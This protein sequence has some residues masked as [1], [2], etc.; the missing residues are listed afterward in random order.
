MTISFA[1]ALSGT[2]GQAIIVALAVLA[3]LAAVIVLLQS[4]GTR[5]QKVEQHLTGYIDTA[6][7][8]VTD[9]QGVVQLAETRIVQ[10]AVGLTSR[11]ADRAG[12]LERVERE[13]ERAEV[14]VRAA[15]AI[16]LWLAAIVSTFL[17]GVVLLHSPIIGLAVAATAA[18]LPLVLVPMRSRKRLRTFEE[19]LP[20]TLKMISG[21][22][23]A[24]FSL[25]QGLDAVTKESVEPT[26]KELGRVYTEARLGRTIEDALGDAADRMESRDLAW[27]V[28]AIRLQREV[29]GNLAELLDTVAETMSER[30]RLRREIRA[31]TAEGRMSGIVLGIFPPAFGGVL[32][33][34]RPNYIDTLFNDG[35]GIAAVVGAAVAAVVGFFWLRKI[36]AIEV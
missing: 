20:D 13:L 9:T 5:K 4:F 32:Y 34:L 8:G 2:A 14:P 27:A 35:L 29:G 25:L 23:R 18:V 10:D 17:V 24:G 15:E 21:S 7:K 11:L 36:V 30:D 31:L 16:F 26:K 22:L 1:A 6:G 12:M 33:V 3:T 28:M 19:Q